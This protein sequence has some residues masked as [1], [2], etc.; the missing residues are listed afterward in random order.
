MRR[1][2]V[3]PVVAIL[4][5]GLLAA[6]DPKFTS[7]WKWMDAK[8]VS[9]AGSKIAALV[10][11]KDES[12]RV[13]GEE[14]LVRELA[15]RGLQAVATY[16][17]IPRPELEDAEKAKV[18][19]DKA[20]VEGVVALR[21]VGSEK[22]KSYSPA[23]WTSAPYGSF[24]GYYP[25]GWSTLYIPASTREDTVIGVETLVFSVKLNQLLWAGMSETKN[26]KNLQQFVKDLVVEAAKEM[27]K[28]G[29]IAKKP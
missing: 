6:E 23:V 11:T 18:W 1:V 7:T 21:P 16:R 29:L 26:P 12:L 24:W 28:Q 10:I 8:S 14:A 13:S 27:Q 22:V 15:G 17:I 4:T 20:A 5:A 3:V 19:Y 2:L 25:Y 9:F